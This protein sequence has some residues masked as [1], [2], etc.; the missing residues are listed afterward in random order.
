MSGKVCIERIC[1]VLETDEKKMRDQ[2][3]QL[4]GQILYNRRMQEILN[5]QLCELTNE[6]VAASKKQIVKSKTPKKP[7]K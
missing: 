1:K 2:V 6:E 4:N 3:V 7:R 5:Q